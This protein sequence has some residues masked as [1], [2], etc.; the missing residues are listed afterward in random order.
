MNSTYGP[1]ARTHSIFP[2]VMRLYEDT[3]GFGQLM[4]LCGKDWSKSENRAA[5]FQMF[6]GEV[7]PRL[8]HLDPDN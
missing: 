5:S 6:M 4:L 1:T 2:G 8:K 7:A 3:G